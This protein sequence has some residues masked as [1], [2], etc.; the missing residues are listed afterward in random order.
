MPC[1]FSPSKQAGDAQGSQGIAADRAFT[2]LRSMNPSS[3]G[4]ALRYSVSLSSPKAAGARNQCPRFTDTET[5]WQMQTSTLGLLTPSPAAP[6]TPSARHAERS[7]ATATSAPRSKKGPAQGPWQHQVPGQGSQLTTVCLA[8]EQ[9]PDEGEA[10]AA[11]HMHQGSPAKCQ[12]G[13]GTP[14]L[15]HREAGTQAEVP[16]L[17]GPHHPHDVTEAQP[18]FILS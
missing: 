6:P 10:V 7:R 1:C 16:F 14:L 12:G 17:M 11:G 18:P 9:G 3:S 2:S 5:E 8:G 15:P 13:Q 4:R